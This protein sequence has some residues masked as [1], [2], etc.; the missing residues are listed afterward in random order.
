VEWRDFGHA[1]N[2][3]PFTSQGV[4]AV[5]LRWGKTTAIRIYCDIVF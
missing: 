2:G 5:S 4:H 1:A 3:M